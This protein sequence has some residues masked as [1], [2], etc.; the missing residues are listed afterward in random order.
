MFRGLGVNMNICIAYES[1]YGNGEKCVDYLHT[2]LN[3]KGRDVTDGYEEKLDI[4][5]REIISGK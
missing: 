3:K 4:F 1:K 2:V 5:A